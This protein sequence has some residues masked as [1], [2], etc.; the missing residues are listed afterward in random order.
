MFGAIAPPRAVM[1]DR[2]HLLPGGER[3]SLPACIT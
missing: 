1:A 2:H 3:R